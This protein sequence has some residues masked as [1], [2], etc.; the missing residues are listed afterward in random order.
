M[1]YAFTKT[2][3]NKKREKHVYLKMIVKI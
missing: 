1:F 3:K 2:E